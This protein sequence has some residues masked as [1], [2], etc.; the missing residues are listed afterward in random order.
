M[1][2]LAQRG[3]AVHHCAAVPLCLYSAVQIPQL[4]INGGRPAVPSRTPH[5]FPASMPTSNSCGKALYA[6]EMPTD[7]TPC[8]CS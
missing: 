7:G 5:N 2:L 6:T 4:V 8:S 1:M 3:E